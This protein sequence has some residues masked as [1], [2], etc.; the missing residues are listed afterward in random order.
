MF[1]VYPILLA[2]PLGYLLGGR[3]ERLGTIRVRWAWL[4]VAGLAVQIVLFSDAVTAVVGAAG[5]PLYVGSSLAVFLVVL[6]N[7]RVTGFPLVAFGAALNLVA[8]LANGGCMPADPAA[9][10]AIGQLEDLDGTRYS[11]SC[12][13]ETVLLAPLTDVLHLPPGMPLANVFSVGDAIIGAGVAVAIVA[14]MRRGGSL[15]DATP[16][17]DPGAPAA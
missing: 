13:P 9:L 15:P 11:N 3:L 6:R 17:A 7:L 14:G 10:A 5:T 1:I 8:I 2:I 4:A 12:I 16:V